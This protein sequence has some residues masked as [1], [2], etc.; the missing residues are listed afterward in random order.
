[1]KPK[2]IHPK[3]R[4]P[5]A[6]YPLRLRPDEA[7]AWLNVTEEHVKNLIRTGSLPAINVGTGSK[8]DCYRILRDDLAAFEEA[9]K[10]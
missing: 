3:S 2:A 10:S 6:S 4:E 7:A 1:M 9:R 8:R 5:L